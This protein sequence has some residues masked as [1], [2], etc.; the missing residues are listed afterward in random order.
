METMKTS[1]FRQDKMTGRR[2]IT[3]DERQEVKDRILDFVES[4]YERY[5]EDRELA[6]SITK[7]PRVT[8]AL[9]RGYIAQS[10]CPKGFACR[11]RKEQ[12]DFI[13][14]VLHSM[15]KQ[16]ALATSLGLGDNGSESRLYEPGTWEKEENDA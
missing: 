9:V 1:Y 8:G 2:A 13:G 5:E 6:P 3:A 7:E 10:R 16:G 4:L 11:S 15:V 14:S 12:A